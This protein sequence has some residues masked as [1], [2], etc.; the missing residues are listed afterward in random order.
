MRI[1]IL[2]KVPRTNPTNTFAVYCIIHVPCIFSCKRDQLVDK[3]QTVY[4]TRE[5]KVQVAQ[6]GRKGRKQVVHFSPQRACVF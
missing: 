1:S 4:L 2:E 5:E 6:N 3:P